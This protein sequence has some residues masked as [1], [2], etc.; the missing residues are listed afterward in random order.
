[1][2]LLIPPWWNQ[3]GAVTRVQTLDAEGGILILTNGGNAHIFL[4]RASRTHPLMLGWFVDWDICLRVCGDVGVRGRVSLT[5][6]DLQCAFGLADDGAS[7][8]K[9]GSHEV[10]YGVPGKFARNGSFLNIPCPGT[11]FLGDPNVSIEVTDEIKEA[12]KKLLEGSGE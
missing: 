9:F 3:E 11:R 2:A 6:K 8:T 12:V 10:E 4:V 5:S 1:M 7:K